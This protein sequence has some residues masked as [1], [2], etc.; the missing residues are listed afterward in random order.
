MVTSDQEPI[1][2]AVRDI[3]TPVLLCDLDALEHNIQKLADHFA[4]AGKRLRPHTKSHK[5]PAIANMQMVAGAI[6]VTCAKLGEAEVMAHAGI[7]DILIANEVIGRRKIERLMALARRC[8][9]MVAV[10]HPDNL[11][12]LEQAAAAAGVQPRVL[13]V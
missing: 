10:D 11:D 2:T 12:D 4:Q 3:D 7:N 9:I 1:G 6:G 8:D 5:T 13:V